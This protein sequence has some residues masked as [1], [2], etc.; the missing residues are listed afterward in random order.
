MGFFKKIFKGVKKVFKKVGRAVKKG[1]K[2]FGKFM[3]KIGIVGQI[4]MMFVLPHVGAFLMKGL[5]GAG[6]A[7][8]AYSGIGSTVVN[9]AGSV[10]T[11]AHKFATAV[12]NGYR[13][14]TQGIMDFGKTALNKIPG[15]SIEGAAQNFFTGPDSALSRVKLNAKS[16]LDPWKTTITGNGRTLGD[17]ARSSG[18]SLEEIAAANQDL[19]KGVQQK[20]W[21]NIVTGENAIINTKAI[22]P[23]PASSTQQMLGFDPDLEQLQA[24]SGERVR[25]AK[26]YMGFDPNR[27]Q[28]L[29]Q[30][31]EVPDVIG[32]ET[33]VQ[34]LEG[35]T[36]DYTKMT[37]G[38]VV[39]TNQ[40]SLLGD[41]SVSKADIKLV[42]ELDT[43]S[44][45][46]KLGEIGGKSI[47]QLRARYNLTE[48][49]LSAVSNIRSDIARFSKP[50][51]LDDGGLR[52]DYGGGYAANLGYFTPEEF[53]ANPVQFNQRLL[54]FES[55]VGQ[56]G[57][58]SNI[59]QEKNIWSQYT[60]SAQQHLMR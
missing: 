8:A 51:E 4:A 50:G 9:A 7:L 34:N 59:Y 5:A 55:N 27:E 48:N 17:I 2:K 58:P 23:L 14:V 52:T 30:M 57:S 22:T 29:A 49:P 38:E 10:L 24:H 35:I 43:G 6:Q 31:G 40:E 25:S 15:V 11:H 12:G 19:I 54:D 16:I 47:E 21:G 39:P 46:G 28:M 41:G 33:G 44:G 36:Q 20:N 60:A 1:F 37:V 13:T 56:W 26:E 53:Q 18:K 3:N 32:P 45:W 42:S